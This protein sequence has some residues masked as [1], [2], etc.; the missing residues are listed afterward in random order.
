[1]G[2]L[3]RGLAYMHNMRIMHRDL[4]PAN[5]LISA[6]GQLKIADFGLSRILEKDESDDESGVRIRKRQYS[7]QVATRWYR[8]PELLYGARYYTEAVDLWSVGC[9]F[10]ELV[11]FSPIFPGE[12]DIDQLGLVIRTMGTPNETIWPGVNQLPDFSKITFP[13]TKPT[14]LENLIPEGDVVV[15]VYR[16]KLSASVPMDVSLNAP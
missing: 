15:V 8:A 13:E 7:H 11:N 5:L 10:G 6:K 4:K 9:I 12:N 14:P 1:M 16:F 3:L 2:M